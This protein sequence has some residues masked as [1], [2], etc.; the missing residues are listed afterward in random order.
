M[1]FD[2]EQAEIVSTLKSMLA[3]EMD[4]GLVAHQIDE[5]VPLLE[6]G[7]GLDSIVIVE[8]IASVERRFDFE[9]QDADLRTSSFESLTALAG[10]IRRRREQ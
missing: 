3:D 6:D 9:F 8:L 7:L 10:V 5:N 2:V 4:L 1:S